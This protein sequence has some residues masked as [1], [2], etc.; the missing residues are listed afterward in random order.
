MKLC[1][2]RNDGSVTGVVAEIQGSKGEMGQFLDWLLD[3]LE[4][5]NKC[6]PAHLQFP[7]PR[8]GQ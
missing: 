7:W 4:T 8:S 3:G 6:V 5:W 1:D 2:A